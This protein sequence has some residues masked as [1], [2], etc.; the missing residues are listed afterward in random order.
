[1][2]CACLDKPNTVDRVAH[3]LD[4]VKGIGIDDLERIV[5]QA[6]ELSLIHI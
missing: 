1:M 5:Q 2:P 3:L 4:A 6:H